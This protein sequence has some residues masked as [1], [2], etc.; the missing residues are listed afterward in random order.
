MNSRAHIFVSGRVQG[1]CFRAYTERWAS[2]MGLKGW[3]RNL[4]DGRVEVMAEGKE[5]KIEELIANLKKGPPSAR[6]E[7]VSVDWQE[8]KGEFDTFRITYSDYF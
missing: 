3:V 7:D 1:V 5:D 2:S 4:S 8:Y 6:V